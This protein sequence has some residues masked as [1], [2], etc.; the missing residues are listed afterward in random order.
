MPVTFKLNPDANYVVATF[1]GVVTDE[2][3]MDAYVTF[4]EGSEWVPGTNELVD[5]SDADVT[6]IT[7]EGLVSLADYTES[8][9]RMH[10]VQNLK[11][12]IYA[13]GDLP[14]GLARMYSSLAASS[15]EKIRVFRR[16]Y[17]AEEWLTGNS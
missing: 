10:H 1:S 16:I 13:P 17:D 5:L 7:V 6:P 15:P 3:V 12:A 14:F 9:F 4:Y 2:D 8:V 11:T